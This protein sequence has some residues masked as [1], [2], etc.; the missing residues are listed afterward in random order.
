MWQET[1]Q[2]LYKQFNFVDFKT[3]FAF[4]SRVADIA[5]GIQH[6]PRWTNDYGM[7]EVWLLSHSADDTITERDRGLAEAI[8]ALSSEFQLVQES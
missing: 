1:D 6:H 4:M 5:E 2:G 8:D 3:A 7:V